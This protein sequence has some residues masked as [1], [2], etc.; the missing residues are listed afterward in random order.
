MDEVYL[1]CMPIDE[2]YTVKCCNNFQ[3]MLFKHLHWHRDYEMIYFNKGHGI[4]NINFNV[5]PFEKGD[6]ALLSPTDFHKI[7]PDDNVECEYL[8]IKIDYLFYMQH[9]TDIVNL[10][11]CPV[12]MHLDKNKRKDVEV[13]LNIL[14]SQYNKEKWRG[15]DLMCTNLIKQIFI[16]MSENLQDNIIK[17]TPN[18]LKEMLLY[19]QT[20]FNK[21]LTLKEVAD[22]VYYSKNHL[23]H[24][25]STHLG[26][27]FK[28]YVMKL[29]LE[30]A[31]SQIRHTNLSIKDIC[32]DS[33]F[34]SLEYFS[35]VF[36][37]KYGISPNNYRKKIKNKE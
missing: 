11:L 10:N 19:I 15:K 24:I 13:L 1:K 21:E 30:Y 31:Y 4:H 20:N 2:S 35:K 6:F 26:I 18:R 29:R 33:G 8:R 23:S 22:A 36:K 7:A 14:L 27:T 34:N 28:E 3:D 12:S 5:Y 37:E 16:L 25:F 32:L 9:L 17:N